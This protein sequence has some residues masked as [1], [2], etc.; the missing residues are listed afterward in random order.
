MSVHLAVGASGNMV[1]TLQ[2]NGS[3]TA[4][5]CTIAAGAPAGTS[6]SDTTHS[7][8]V[9]LGQPIFLHVRCNTT[10]GFDVCP[11]SV[12]AYLASPN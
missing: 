2:V 3:D 8:A 1:G 10:T 9:S 12:W 4:V 6:C 5:T 7:A 11:G